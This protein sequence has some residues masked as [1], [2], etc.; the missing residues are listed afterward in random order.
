M[1]RTLILLVGL[2][3]FLSTGALARAETATDEI[4]AAVGAVLE[5]ENLTLKMQVLRLTAERQL[6]DMRAQVDQHVRAFATAAG[7]DPERYLLDLEKRVW[8]KKKPPSPAS[9]A[10]SP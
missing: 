3:V 10:P 6:S 1:K 2:G 9:S 8:R 4:P 5:V 7:L